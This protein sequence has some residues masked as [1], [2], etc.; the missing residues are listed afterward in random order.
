MKSKIR[1]TSSDV[2]PGL[3]LQEGE[4]VLFCGCSNQYIRNPLR[5]QPRWPETIVLTNHRLV[6]LNQKPSGLVTRTTA[7]TMIPLHQ[8]DSVATLSVR[9]TFFG[10][11]ACVLLFCFLV[12]PGVLMLFHMRQ[13]TGPRVLVVSGGVVVEIKFSRRSA[14]LLRQFSG[15]L[16]MYV[17]SSLQRPLAHH[18]TAARLPA[19]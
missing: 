11:L 17:G 2:L 10:I 13:T 18:H 12:I 15:Q 5:E 1:T 16:D 8:I 14:E 7:V 3:V 6:M 9:W 19:A 4:E